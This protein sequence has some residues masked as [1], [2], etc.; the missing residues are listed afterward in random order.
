MQSIGLE[1]RAGIVHT[2]L[3]SSGSS[4]GLLHPWSLLRAT[5]MGSRQGS[6][7]KLM[8]K[9]AEKEYLAASVVS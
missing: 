2:T 1:N 5:E 3:V 9:L 6:I 4:M 8:V 7:K